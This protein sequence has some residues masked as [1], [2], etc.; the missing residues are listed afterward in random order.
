MLEKVYIVGIEPEVSVLY[1][2]PLYLVVDV[3]VG[4]DV[5]PDY[6]FPDL[7][8][9]HHLCWLLFLPNFLESIKD[10]YIVWLLHLFYAASIFSAKY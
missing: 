7:M 9:V 1:E 2:E 3:L 5:D 8:A 10:F 6:I 4:H